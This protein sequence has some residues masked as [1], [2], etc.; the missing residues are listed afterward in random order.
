M[1]T[2]TSTGTG[3]S[4]STST[5]TGTQHEHEHDARRDASA[6]S[7]GAGKV[8]FLD[9]PSGLAGDMIIA[10]LVDLGVP[11]QVVADALA[12]LPLTGFHVHFGTRVRSGIVAHLVRG[13]RRRA[14]ADAHLRQHP[15]HA[16][17][18]PLPEG[19]QARA[20][21][22]FRRLAEAEAKVHRSPID[23]VH[24]H[25]VGAVDAIVDVVGSAAALD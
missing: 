5:T 9:A 21:R 15:R 7:R 4:T 22:T 19:V 6:A 16:R 1:G 3:T 12:A 17:R 24:F 23:D 25:E 14:A 10:A 13:A 11:A 18:A 8:L 20:Q 2:S